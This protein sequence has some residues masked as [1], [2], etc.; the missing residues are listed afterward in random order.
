LVSGIF[1]ADACERGTVRGVSDRSHDDSERRSERKV[2]VFEKAGEGMRGSRV[3]FEDG[4]GVEVDE[5]EIVGHAR[6]E[7]PDV[8]GGWI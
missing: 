7:L 4:D 8:G 3:Q 2:R 6:V 5:I 1:G